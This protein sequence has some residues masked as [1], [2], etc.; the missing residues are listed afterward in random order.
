L[1]FELSELK[2]KYNSAFARALRDYLLLA[3]CG[4]A[5]HAKEKCEYYSP[6]FARTERQAVFSYITKYDKDY[7]I[8]I[9][10]GLF[11]EDWE[12][13]YGGQA[14]LSIIEAIEMY[15]TV[16]DM[17]FIDHC[18]DL[19]HNNGLCFDK[20][21]I[22]NLDKEAVMYLLDRKREA[23]D[24]HKI[25]CLPYFS[26]IEKYNNNLLEKERLPL[27]YDLGYTYK[28][29]PAI[30][31]GDLKPKGKAILPSNSDEDLID[32]SNQAVKVSIERPKNDEEED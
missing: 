18:I 1:R 5:R 27:D 15:K 7:L 25:S 6:L 26:F 19:E 8:R 10:K 3:S 2:D 20:G 30:E 13:S 17:V 23:E 32:Y 28:G 16:P 24:L 31:W 4:E 9:L 12:G 14:W 22:F 29:F 21:I 11:S